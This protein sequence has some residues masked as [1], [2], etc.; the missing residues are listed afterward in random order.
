MF[1]YNPKTT[2][3]ELVQDSMFG[4]IKSKTGILK[5]M[6]M[7]YLEYLVTFKKEEGRIKISSV[8]IKRRI[9]PCFERV[10]EKEINFS[11]A[12]KEEFLEFLRKRGAK[13]IENSK[14][15][16]EYI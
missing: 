12:T 11:G 5:P 15:I 6:H 13:Q 14:R 10:S 4:L 8:L 9:F 16:L 7:K 1:S 3:D 2:I